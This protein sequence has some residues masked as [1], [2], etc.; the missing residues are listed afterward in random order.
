[1]VHPGDRPV[2]PGAALLRAQHSVDGD[3]KHGPRVGDG[4]EVVEGRFGF[5]RFAVQVSQDVCPGYVTPEAPRRQDVRRR[6]RQREFGGEPV[7]LEVKAPV[8]AVSFLQKRQQ[9]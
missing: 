1:M 7:V 9:L 6:R 3:D 2:H 5:D 8:S 4:L